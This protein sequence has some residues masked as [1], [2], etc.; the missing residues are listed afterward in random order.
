M[1]PLV[2]SKIKIDEQQVVVPPL[3]WRLPYPAAKL[4]FSVSRDFLLTFVR[5]TILTSSNHTPC[6]PTYLTS[7]S[8][9]LLRLLLILLWGYTPSSSP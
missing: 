2:N 1:V 9:I 6:L 3:L 5:A 8:S 7:L 4:L